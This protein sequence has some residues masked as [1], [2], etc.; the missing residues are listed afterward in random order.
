MLRAWH[1]IA[2]KRRRLIQIDDED[3]QVAIIVKIS[4]GATTA[5]MLCT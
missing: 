4:K 5:A 1:V 2:Q 3:V